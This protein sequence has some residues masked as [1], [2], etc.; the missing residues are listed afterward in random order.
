MPSEIVCHLEK[1]RTCHGFSTL[2]KAVPPR[3]FDPE[4]ISCHVV[5][6][7]PTKYFPYISGYES[8]AKTPKLV[9][10]GCEDCHGPGENHVKAQKGNNAALQKQLQEAMRLTVEEAQNPNNNKTNCRSCH[11]QDNSP[12]FDFKEYW[13]YI[14]HHESE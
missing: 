5:G 12:E 6:W 11:D 2:Q 14:E 9:N 3:E 8:Q 1:E 4:C 10:V 13:K 7:H